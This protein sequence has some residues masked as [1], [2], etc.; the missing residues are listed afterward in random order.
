M[1]TIAT[2]LMTAEEFGE[3]LLL[4][5]NAGGRYEL[6]QGRVVTMPSPT[7]FHGTVCWLV[8]RALGDYVFHRGAGSLAT[9]DS[10]LIVAR[11]PDTV[12]GPDIMLFLPVIELDDIPRRPTEEI[13]SLVVEVLSPTDTQTKTL[14]RVRQYHGRGIP[15]VWVIDPEERTVHV[16]RPHEFPKVLDESETLEGNGVLPEFSCPVARLFELPKPAVNPNQ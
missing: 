1:A 15:L 16:Y 10:S 7:R 14:R 2:E 9:N 12:R 11:N 3:W 6:V 4:P 13:P 8:S 5:I